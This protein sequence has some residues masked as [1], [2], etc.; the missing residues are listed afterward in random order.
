M[1]IASIKGNE[2]AVINLL[3][4]GCNPNIKD[5]AGWTPLHEASNHGYANIV[6]ILLQHGA[7][8]NMI[9]WENST[10]LHDAVINNHCKVAEILLKYGADTGARNQ[11]GETPLE[12]SFT[13]EMK[14]IL[15]F[16]S[17]NKIVPLIQNYQ[18]KYDQ[19]C[20]MVTGLSS[21]QKHT[22]EKCAKL[23]NFTIAKD[24]SDNVTHLIAAC[25]VKKHCPRTLKFLQG[26]L[27][28]CWIV[29]FCWIQK[30]IENQ[31]K[32]S[33]EE[34]EVIGAG[35]QVESYGPKKARLNAEKQYPPLFN[36][37]QFYILGNF[38]APLPSNE[39]FC[40]L[41]KLGGGKLLSREPRLDLSN[42]ELTVPYHAELENSLSKC[43]YFI[44]SSNPT[45][46][47]TDRI[48]RLPADW[49]LDSIGAFSLL[50]PV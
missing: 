32:V 19:I 21:D 38:P 35:N 18:A 24:Y 25:N 50:D 47:I 4:E 15:E 46:S 45:I 29:D 1:H 9:G 48:C 49:L 41:V 14:R 22:V 23:L 12:L 34:F 37:C 28:G 43:T 39:Q 20:I 3:R 5:N 33:E 10:P 17:K 13:P 26:I 44:I 31:S 7:V 16:H 36:G 11:R 2:N 6:E 30:C 8:V 40:A 42:S 27:C